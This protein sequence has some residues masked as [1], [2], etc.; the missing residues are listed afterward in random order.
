M[1]QILSP[2]FNRKTGFNLSWAGRR[3]FKQEYPHQ[4]GILRPIDH[5]SFLW[6]DE[7]SFEDTELETETRQTRN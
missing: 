6:T 1:N 5:V 2:S 3:K 7:F 4:L